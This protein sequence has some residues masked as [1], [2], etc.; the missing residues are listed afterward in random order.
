VESISELADTHFP[1]D[2]TKGDWQLTQMGLLRLEELQDKHPV[3]A[4]LQFPHLLLTL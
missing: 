3:T 2:I 4:S 1:Y